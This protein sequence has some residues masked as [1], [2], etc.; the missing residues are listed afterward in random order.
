MKSVCRVFVMLL[1]CVFSVEVFAQEDP[2]SSFDKFRSEMLS[3]FQSF[4]KSVL[5][6]YADFLDGIWKEY[7]RFRG[8]TRDD[9]P[10][11]DTIPVAKD[12]PEEPVDVPTPDV[13]PQKLPDTVVLPPKP[14]IPPVLPKVKFQFCGAVWE[15]PKIEVVS[16]SRVEGKS[17]AKVWNIYKKN[18]VAN[19][20]LSFQQL[21][22]E[23]GFNDWFVFE[24]IKTYVNTLDNGSSADDRIMLQHFLLLNMGYDV[25][26]S[27]TD[28]GNL[29]LLVPFKQ[30]VYARSYLNINGANY[31]IFSG[32]NVNLDDNTR[33]Y[34]CVLPDSLD[35]GKKMNLLYHPGTYFQSGNLKKNLLTD[36]HI[37]VEGIVDVEIMEMVRHYPLMDIAD[38]A[39]STLMPSLRSDILRQ[40]KPYLQGL[41]QQE[42]VQKLMHFMHYA[43]TYETDGDQHGYEKPYFVEEN[44]YYAKNDCEDRSIFFAFLVREL[45][46]MEVHLVFYPGHACTA[47]HFDDDNIMGDGYWYENKRYL[48]C[49]PTYIGANI[50]MCMPDFRSVKPEICIY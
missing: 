36:G 28:K 11:P 32:D 34:S 8:L 22:F 9:T 10:K 44:F 13:L 27:I 23:E 19:I 30:I 48:I 49:D 12:I 1:F 47:I 21:A 43:F 15:A 41:S 45:L 24:M 14:V 2:N 50:G 29:L 25:R 3:N 6:N 16:L 39:M 31:Y 17:L 20:A 42:A 26:L 35:Y 37:Q 46:Q 38:Y 4:R 33:F 18:D 7:D 40:V 5:D